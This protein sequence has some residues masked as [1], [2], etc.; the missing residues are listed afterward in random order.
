M[1]VPQVCP[2][3]NAGRGGVA[4]GG[5]ALTHGLTLIICIDN[6]LTPR[7]KITSPLPSGV[8]QRNVKSNL[9]AADG[10][11]EGRKGKGSDGRCQSRV[12]MT[13]SALGW[14][15]DEGS[16]VRSFHLTPQARGKGRRLA[17][18]LCG[19]RASTRSRTRVQ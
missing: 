14:P 2:A 1:S 11:R 5:I 18:H 6:T 7:P 8:W 4:R 3:R 10:T 13:G 12:G 16:G 19:S 9:R 17:A 15:G